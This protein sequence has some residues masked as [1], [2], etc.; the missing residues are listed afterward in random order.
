[1][2]VNSVSY[3]IDLTASSG[4]KPRQEQNEAHQ[5]GRDV[6]PDNGNDAQAAQATKP[7]VNTSGHTVGTVINTKA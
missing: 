7:T 4:A 3:S 1:M 5:S 6:T 2:D